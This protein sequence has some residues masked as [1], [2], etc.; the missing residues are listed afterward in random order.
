MK[1]LRAKNLCLGMLT[2]ETASLLY[3]RKGG[4]LAVDEFRPSKDK[5]AD[6][7]FSTVCFVGR[8]TGEGDNFRGQYSLDVQPANTLNEPLKGAVP[9]T[10][11]GSGWVSPRQSEVQLPSSCPKEMRTDKRYVT[12]V[13]KVAPGVVMAEDWNDAALI[14]ASRPI[15]REAVDNL[16]EQYGCG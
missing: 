13:L 15:L 11:G 5:Q 7:V 16:A 8:E 4:K 12:V 1:N 14:K 6:P 10:D 3:D 2:E 9:F